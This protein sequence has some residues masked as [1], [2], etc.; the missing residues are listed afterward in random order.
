V[1]AVEDHRDR[2]QPPGL[3][4]IT[5]LCRQG[6]ELFRSWESRR[7]GFSGGWYQLAA[8]IH[9][10]P[11]RATVGVTRSKFQGVRRAR[12]HSLILSGFGCAMNGTTYEPRD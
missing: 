12:D 6:A 7:V 9:P 10:R 3:A 1:N 5:A 11:A 2:Q 4:R 8:G